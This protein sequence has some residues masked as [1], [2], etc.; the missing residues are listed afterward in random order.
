MS[1]NGNA[2]VAAQEANLPDADLQ[3]I[4]EEER[5]QALAGID[6][7]PP[8]VGIEPRTQQ[9]A[10]V[11]TGDLVKELRVVVVFSHKARGFWEEGNKVP[12]CTSMDGRT[13]Q[14]DPG[15]ACATCPLN[16]FGSDPK[17]GNGKAC[18]EMR[19]LYFVREEDGL[20]SLLTLPPTSIG[21]WDQYVSALV[22]RKDTPGTIF[23]ETVLRL[24][25]QEDKS[26]GYTWSVLKPEQGQRVPMPHMLELRKLRAAI[27]I[28]ATKYGVEA[29]DY[30]ATVD[31]EA[32][33]SPVGDEAF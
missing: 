9:F 16:Q 17:G 22:G 20:P 8:R 23:V 10:F 11:A 31:V 27:E 5:K 15:G 13:G 29:E 18:K 14:G 32:E 24:E 3:R 30:G 4:F 12:V 26:R 21:A 2:L 19:R 28:A 33:A 25:K 7:R 6:Y 1:T